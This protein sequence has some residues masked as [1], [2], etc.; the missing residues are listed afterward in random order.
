MR[1]QVEHYDSR[2]LD[3]VP[4]AGLEVSRQGANDQWLP[5]GLLPGSYRLRLLSDQSTTA[6]IAINRGDSLLLR[7]AEAGGRLSFSRAD[8][9]QDDFSW[10]PSAETSAWRLSLLENQR[11]AQGNLRLLV[12]L[13]NRADGPQTS[14]QQVRPREA[15]L[16]V[17]PQ[18][19]TAARWHYQP[20]YPAAAWNVEVPAWP[21]AADGLSPAHPRV[22]LWWNADQPATPAAVVRRGHDFQTLADLA[23][24]PVRVAGDEVRIESVCVE[25]H[26]VQT[27]PGVR[28]EQ[29]CLVVRLNHP[30]QQ[31]V[32]VRVSGVN[33]IGQEHRCYAS[34]GSYTGL[35]WPVT[36]DEAELSLASVSLL[37]L[38]EFKRESQK[39][40]CTLRLDDLPPPSANDLRPAPLELP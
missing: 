11:S 7:L 38:E 21:Q 24:R 29:S 5:G 15:W 2:P 14:L 27:R 8:W 1:Y 28:Q 34:I 35:F 4:A 17:Q 12:A 22:Q 3:S 9:L 13:E 26:V 33:P 18:A 6:N 31:G 37:S 40:G 32:W 19:G 39:R 25:R 36:P 16:E 30:P 10:K 23:G 20:G